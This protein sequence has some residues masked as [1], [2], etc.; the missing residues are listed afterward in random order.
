MIRLLTVGVFPRGIF[1]GSSGWLPRVP[2][3]VL[4]LIHLSF[5]ILFPRFVD[6][7]L[8]LLGPGRLSSLLLLCLLESSFICDHVL[9]SDKMSRFRSVRRRYG[10]DDVA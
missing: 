2:L 8:Y 10:P 4:S 9:K 6:I 5:D 1:Q 3:P 7:V